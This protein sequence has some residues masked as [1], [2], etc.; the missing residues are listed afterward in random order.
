[1]N[2]NKPFTT[3]AIPNVINSPS[4]VEIEAVLAVISLCNPFV[5][6]I[7]AYVVSAFTLVKYD[8]ATLFTVSI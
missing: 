4:I 2:V 1:M 5:I 6:A 3:L 8:L 7:V